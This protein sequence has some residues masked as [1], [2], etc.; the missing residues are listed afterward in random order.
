M[1]DKTMKYDMS[2]APLLDD[3]GHTNTISPLDVLSDDGHRIIVRS[4][5]SAK[6][7]IF[8]Y[9]LVNDQKLV[10]DDGR[11]LEG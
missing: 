10:A 7:F 4:P 1:I 9:T 8:S 3:G 2:L 6:T 5:F 11:V